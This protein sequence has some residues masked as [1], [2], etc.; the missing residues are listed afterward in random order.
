[1]DPGVASGDQLVEL[2]QFLAA[3]RLTLRP[4]AS[5]SQPSCSASRIRAV[6]LSLISESRWAAI[7]DRLTFAGQIIETG[8][9]SY[10]LAHAHQRHT[11]G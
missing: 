8:T 7:V 6:R 10:R 1:M 11:P 2:D 9:T 5:P 3:A 4:S